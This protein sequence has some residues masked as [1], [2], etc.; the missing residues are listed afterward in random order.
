MSGVLIKMGLYGLLRTILLLGAP[1]PWVGASLAIIGFVS[2]SVGIAL[3]LYQRDVK[4]VLAYSSIENVGIIT[5]GLGMGLWGKASGFPHVAALAMAGALLHVWNHTLMKGLMFLGAGSVL[6]GCGTKD[7]E[8]LGG[9]LK[10]MPRT[11]TLLVFGAVALAALPPLNGFSSEWL[12]YLGLIEAGQTPD[13]TA[14]AGA[15]LGVGVVAIVGALAV[16]SFVRLVGIALLGQPRSASADHAHESPLA[17]TAP[18]AALA[19][20]C[21]VVGVAPQQ[22]VKAIGR[23][24][25]ELLGGSLQ[26]TPLT[27]L[28]AMLGNLDGAIWVAL[29]VTTLL[30]LINVRSRKSASGPTWGCGY[31]ASTARVQYTARS[32][33]E[34]AT[35]KLLP[36]FLRPRLALS[37]APDLFPP[38]GGLS[39]DCTDPLTR[40]VYEP[41]FTRSADRFARLRWVQQGVLHDYILYI[42]VAVLVAFGWATLRNWNVP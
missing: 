38:A 16:L 26:A 37:V 3:S 20:A 5:I 32:F 18:M 17:M 19:L 8:K 31:V 25:S 41:L 33:S 36:R 28:L 13:R 40:K 35:E 23:V 39:S 21:L 29:V 12:V 14:A 9:V 30:V 10:R 1:A 6:H 2:A 7:L 4:R 11:G 42:A 24:A 34:L 22:V 15:L 27:A